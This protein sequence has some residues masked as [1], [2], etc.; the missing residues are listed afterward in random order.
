M[1]RPR[2][3]ARARQQVIDEGVAEQ[4]GGQERGPEEEV[5]AEV[6]PQACPLQ[7]PG[8]D[9]V[10]VVLLPGVKGQKDEEQAQP[11]NYSVGRADG[12]HSRRPAV[13][14]QSRKVQNPEAHK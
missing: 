9:R 14:R 1:K 12:F 13:P 4:P 11:Q 10:K 3:A 8:H 5:Q 7:Y 6:R 2:F